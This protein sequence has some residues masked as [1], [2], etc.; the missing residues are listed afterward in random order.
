VT[1]SLGHVLDA[2]AF[3]FHPPL[4]VLSLHGILPTLHIELLPLHFV[5]MLPH[6]LSSRLL[7][8]LQGFSRLQ[9]SK[10]MQVSS[11]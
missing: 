2:P 10:A 5:M 3:G 1:L 11:R 6:A 8:V 7:K 4:S 9:S